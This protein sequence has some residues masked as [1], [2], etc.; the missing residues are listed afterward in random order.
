MNIDLLNPEHREVAEKS[1]QKII[2]CISRRALKSCGDTPEQA[3]EVRP[4]DQ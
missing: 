2:D 4:I 1:R 3:P